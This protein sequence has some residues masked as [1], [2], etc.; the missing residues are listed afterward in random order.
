MSLFLFFFLYIQAYKCPYIYIWSCTYSFYCRCCVAVAHSNKFKCI[1]GLYSGT[2]SF[3]KWI[4]YIF[5]YCP[6]AAVTSF[7]TFLG[8][9]LIKQKQNQIVVVACKSGKNI[10]NARLKIRPRLGP[11]HKFASVRARFLLEYVTL[12]PMLYGPNH[13]L[14]HI[15]YIATKL[16][17]LKAIKFNYSLRLRTIRP[18]IWIML[19]IKKQF[20]IFGC[21]FS[22]YW[23]H[24]KF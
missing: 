14:N 1:Y 8:C 24:W 16:P 7:A 6:Q 13:A 11:I 21:P 2:N 4:V 20:N 10:V 3:G 18:E 19:I 12:K 22:N 17:N 15:P 23:K 9:V 5:T